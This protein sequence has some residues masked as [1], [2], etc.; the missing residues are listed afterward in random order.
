[1]HARG[2]GDAADQGVTREVT[3]TPPIAVHWITPGHRPLRP[4]ARAPANMARWKAQSERMA[5]ATE[6][7]A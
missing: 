7:A 2:H 6:A 1:M 3:M 5:K 4:S